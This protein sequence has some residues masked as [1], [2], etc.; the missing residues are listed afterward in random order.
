MIAILNYGSG[1]NGSIKNM[2]ARLGA[3]SYI[4][5]NADDLSHAT[6]LILPGVGNF[7]AAINAINSLH[8]LR[9][10]LDNLALKKKIPI[11][12]LCLG[13]Q[14]MTNSS[15]ESRLSGL[16][17]I[18]SVTLKFQNHNNYKFPHT[19]WNSILKSSDSFL[20]AS[21]SENQKF[22]FNHSFYVK[23][24][25]RDNVI[26]NTKYSIN[27]DS[28]IQDKNIIGLQFHPEKSHRGGFKI[29]QNFI[30]LPL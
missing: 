7:D 4:C 25:N 19:G 20:T 9:K 28:G 6:K 14:L 3:Q 17:W 10:T 24:H 26:L 15:E 8:N 5:N 11:L 27:F 23:A 29:F 22:Y 30:N 12:G 13:M 18:D 16:G 1:N 21:L 2:L